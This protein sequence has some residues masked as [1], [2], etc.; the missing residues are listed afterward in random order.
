MKYALP[1]LSPN[2]PKDLLA[3]LVQERVDEYRSFAVLVMV[4]GAFL[5]SAL[6]IWDFA[7]DEDGAPRA[8]PYRIVASLILLAFA[9]YHRWGGAPRLR[10]V[11]FVA[12]MIG[13]QAV[14]YPIMD[15]L[16]NGHLI[17]VGAYLYWLIFLPLV[18][19]GLTLQDCLAGL[20]A[21]C[22]AP[23]V[24]HALGLTPQFLPVVFV[25]YTW[26]AAPV[27]AI[28]ATV[29]NRLILRML[30]TRRM[31][32]EAHEQARALA[33]T[34]PLTG[35]NNRRA[36]LELGE[37]LFLNAARY[38]H[39]LSAL[40][41]DLDFFKA[42]NDTY[43]HAAGD[44]VLVE[45]ASLM[46]RTARA[47]DVAGRIGGEEFVLILPDSDQAEAASLAERLRAA[48]EATVVEGPDGDIRFTASIGVA[49]RDGTEA[50]L[51][52]ICKADEALY[53]AKKAGRNQVS[54]AGG[55]S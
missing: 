32:E 1:T 36:A 37:V 14:V 28:V 34:D 40:V 44:A 49:D 9:A 43:G 31:L 55:T 53:A 45:A 51:D 4:L 47:S 22:V 54:V 15:Q 2:V 16:E 12:T 27:V 3:S 20:L 7:I 11:V 18:G 41:M 52:L 24:W 10:T 19:I 25:V 48:V 8:F 29:V 30:Y 38:D 13:S 35:L 5:A 39:P 42:I 17:G 26:I 6:T 21:V 50:L 46:T 23:L 33:R